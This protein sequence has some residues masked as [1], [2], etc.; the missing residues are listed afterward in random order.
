[1]NTCINFLLYLYQQV[2]ANKKE[3][4]DFNERLKINTSFEEAIRVLVQEEPHKEEHKKKPLVG[5][6]TNGSK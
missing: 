6:T 5:D 2:M 1:M 4:K 3:K